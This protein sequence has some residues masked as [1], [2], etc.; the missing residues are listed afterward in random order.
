LD[1][2]EGKTLIDLIDD[3]KIPERQVNKPF[4]MSINNY[5]NSQVGK[6]RGFCLSGKIESGVIK[7]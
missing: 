4:R 6:M 7:K 1:W 2:W 5:Y 3:L